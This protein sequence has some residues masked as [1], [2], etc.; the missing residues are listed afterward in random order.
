M[1]LFW[2]VCL[3]PAPS[4]NRWH[5]DIVII[6]LPAK[7]QLRRTCISISHIDFQCALKIGDCILLNWDNLPQ[8]RNISCIRHDILSRSFSYM[9]G[10]YCVAAQPQW[11][12][13]TARVMQRTQ[14][15]L[16]PNTWTRIPMF[17]WIFR[18]LFVFCFGFSSCAW[19]LLRSLWLLYFF[20]L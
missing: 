18:Y 8:I 15:H 13:V 20:L 12:C 1:S 7:P 19:G 9:A 2:I 17:L 6:I 3:L 5:V 10:R 11:W 4:S 14:S 16:D